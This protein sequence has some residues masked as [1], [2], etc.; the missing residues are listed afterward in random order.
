MRFEQLEYLLAITRHTSLRRAG[1]ELHVSQSALSEA[2]SR[3]ERELGVRLLERQRS[4]V[5][6]SPAGRE[7]LP[8]ITDVL[9]AVARLRSAA[10]DGLIAG[11]ELRLGT[12]STG[13]AAI[14]LPAVRAFQSARDGVTV[15][16]R[17]LQRAE[18]VAGL[19]EGSL[20]L[21]LVNMLDG[22]DPLPGL[23]SIPLLT[24]RPVAVV[25]S[26]HP[27]AAWPSVDVDDLRGE[28]FIGLRSGYQMHRIAHRLFGTDPPAQRHAADG[29][30][31]AKQMVAAGIGVAVL[32]D[33]SVTDDPLL[34]AGLL[35]VVPL[36][37]TQPTVTMAALH[38]AKERLPEAVHDLLSHLVVRARGLVRDSSLR[39]TAGTSP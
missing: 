39:A 10:G 35:A 8:S 30:E 36:A 20:D 18:V 27:F 34:A 12:V 3:L 22:D 33:F 15:E 2:I 25:P 5:R 11:R 32:P 1:E 4:G 17:S 29:A 13:T 24:G 37:V 16:I 7:L 26:Q 6:I 21:G 9:D 38:P 31:M 28:R 14:V 23:E 19:A